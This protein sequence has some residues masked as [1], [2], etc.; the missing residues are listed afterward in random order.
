MAS[1]RAR[2]QAL[3]DR[4]LLRDLRVLASIIAKGARGQS[5]TDDS[6]PLD[7]TQIYIDWMYGRLPAQHAGAER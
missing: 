1:L 6:A 4:V 2:A 7:P 3:D 5:A